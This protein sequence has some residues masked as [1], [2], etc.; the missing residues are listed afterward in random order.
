MEIWESNIDTPVWNTARF[1]YLSKECVDE[2]RN[3][4]ALGE[5][6]QGT[7]QEEHQHDGKQPVALPEFQ[8]FP[9]LTD[10]GL[11]CHLVYSSK[12]G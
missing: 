10:D 6:N 11:I 4:T 5:N 1:R 2:W 9:E 3:R 8:K 12:P 7:E